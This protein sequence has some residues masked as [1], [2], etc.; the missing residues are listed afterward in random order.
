MKRTILFVIL[1]LAVAYLA[2]LGRAG[3]HEPDE[4]RYAEVSREMMESGNLLI[5]TQNGI[6][7]FQKPPVIYWATAATMFLFGQ[8]EIG[9][10]MTPILSALGVLLLTYWIGQR[11]FDRK[12]GRT[13]VW[14][15]AGGLEFYIL[16][17]GL[18]PDMLMT[19]WIMAAIAAF[20]WART[21]ASPHKLRFFPFFIFMGIAFSTKGPMGILVPLFTAIGWQWAS[22]R[23]ADKSARI[24]WITGIA[25][26]LLISVS[27]FMA[28]SARHPELLEYFV[29]YEFIDRFFSKTHGRSEPFWFFIPV[30]IF[31]WVPWTPLFPLAWSRQK[32]AQLTPPGAPPFPGPCLAG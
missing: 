20:V 9:A 13:A 16:A 21:H 26:T 7:H 18:C 22:R 19:F 27:W 23:S 10:R 29:K 25:V 1:V 31:G 14:L 4:A 2:F 6:P 8:N 11:W 24:P 28:C 17:R 30:I 15:L 5:P 3:L 32:A 12:T